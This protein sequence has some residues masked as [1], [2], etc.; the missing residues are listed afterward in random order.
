MKR[1]SLILAVILLVPAAA[2]AQ[3]DVPEFQPGRQVVD[4]DH[5]GLMMNYL[6]PVE[7]DIPPVKFL[8]QEE[9]PSLRERVD[10]LLYG[11]KVDIPPEYDHYGYEIRRYMAHV[12]SPKALG[13]EELLKQELAN[14]KKAKIIHQYWRKE[15]MKE[16]DAIKKEIEATNPETDIRTSFK[17]NSGLAMAFMTECGGWIEK[18]E[19]LISFLIDKQ[20][21][22]TFKEPNF[23]FHNENE[24]QIFAQHYLAAKEAREYINEY[25]PFA[26]MVF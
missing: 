9:T 12:A 13:N 14:I 8:K 19:K 20:G 4:P 1:F 6:P 11:I 23:R 10:R 18:N 25:V 17:Y 3:M 16:I 26:T 22:Y 2:A 24:K 15:W 5:P 21:A 7:P